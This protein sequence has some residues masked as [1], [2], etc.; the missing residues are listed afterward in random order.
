MK[1]PDDIEVD[2]DAFEKNLK[3]LDREATET[4]DEPPPEW[5]GHTDEYLAYLEGQGEDL[6]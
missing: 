1:K 2:K 4:E 6:R 5:F 3:A